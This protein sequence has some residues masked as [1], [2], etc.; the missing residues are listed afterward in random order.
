MKVNIEEMLESTKNI[1]NY[2]INKN[3]KTC[4]LVGEYRGELGEYCGEVGE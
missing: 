4:G 1:I 2:N 3:K